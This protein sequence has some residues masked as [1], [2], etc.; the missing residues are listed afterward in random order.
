M[1]DIAA[2]NRQVANS[3]YNLGLE[4]AKIRDLSGAAQCLKKKPAFFQIP[5]RCQKSPGSDLL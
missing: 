5:D 4:K 3:Y 1:M 2:K